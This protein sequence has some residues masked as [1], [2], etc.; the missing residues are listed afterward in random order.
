MRSPRRLCAV[1]DARLLWH[2]Q[3]WAEWQRDR[4]ADFGRGYPSCAYSIGATASRDFE[5]MCAE[6]DNR[7]ALAVDATVDGLPAPERCAVHAIHLDA[8]WRFA[9]KR[10]DFYTLACGAIRRGLIRRGIV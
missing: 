6:L 8:R 7:C 3:N 2:L 5:A 9:G 4:A 10:A 1:N